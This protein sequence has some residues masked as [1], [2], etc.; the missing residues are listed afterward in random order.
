MQKIGKEVKIGLAVIGVLLSTFG[1]VLYK[2]LTKPN[3]LD[4][5]VAATADPAAQNSAA[6]DRP[7]VVA[8]TDSEKPGDPAAGDAEPGHSAWGHSSSR[9]QDQMFNS[10]A[11]HQPDNGAADSAGPR[12][13]AFLPA[14]RDSSAAPADAKSPGGFFAHNDAPRDAAAHDDDHHARAA[15]PSDSGLPGA[16]ASSDPFQ[17]PN[18][19]AADAGGSGASSGSALTPVDTP[20]LRATGAGDPGADSNPVRRSAEASGRSSRAVDPD[21]HLASGSA[22]ADAGPTPPSGAA[23]GVVAPAADGLAPPGGFS[24][25]NGFSAAPVSP[26]SNAASGG[27]NT[28]SNGPAAPGGFA[29]LNGAAPTAIAAPPSSNTSP[30]NLFAAPAAGSSAPNN[31]FGGSSGAFAPSS[32]GFNNATPNNPVPP[33]TNNPPSAFAPT[34]TNPPASFPQGA[35]FR[36]T[37]PPSS[38][39]IVGDPNAAPAGKYVVQPNDNYWIISKKVYGTGGY[40][41][42]IYEHNRRQHPKADRLQVG[43]TLETPDVAYLQK[44][45]PDLC[46]TPGHASAPQRT[47]AASA[48]VR[49]GTRVYIVEE[50]DTLFEIARRELGKPS[51]WGEIYQMNRE[52]LGSDFDYLKPGTELLLPGDSRPDTLTRQPADT[53]SR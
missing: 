38:A 23:P 40:F 44:N 51:R 34:S 13:A 29:P 37:E 49:P 41:K 36:P 18:R 1:V 46:P 48:R 14:N 10:G 30:P 33:P 17:R 21:A 31:P 16:G 8:A 27:N 7:T 5:A 42:A 15:A 32:G 53:S 6:A 50:G 20:P 45:Y 25:G 28:P 4:V 22:P 19:F 35:D 26:P 3:D 39:A 11:G 9:L 2:R 43:E 47:M 12:D 24:A 52:T